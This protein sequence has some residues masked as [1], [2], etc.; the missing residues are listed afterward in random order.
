MASEDSDEYF[1]HIK[2]QLNKL[3]DIK[4]KKSILKCSKSLNKIS[5]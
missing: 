1:A 5:D 2:S 3:S 4:P